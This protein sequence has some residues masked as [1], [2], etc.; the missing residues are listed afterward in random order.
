[1]KGRYWDPVHKAWHEK[2][3]SLVPEQHRQ[4]VFQSWKT[5][6]PTEFNHTEQKRMV[7]QVP[8]AVI[9][10]S[11]AM[12]KYIEYKHD[13]FNKLVYK[14]HLTGSKFLTTAGRDESE[15]V[16]LLPKQDHFE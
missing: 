8:R 2:L 13:R 6:E 14:R 15:G 10:A 16:T 11:I 1:M 9:D 5:N 12:V 3:V 7:R 4:E